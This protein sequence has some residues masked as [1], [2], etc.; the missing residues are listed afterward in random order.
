ML[1]CT[2]EPVKFAA[3]WTWKV[4]RLSKTNRINWMMNETIRNSLTNFVNQT[5]NRTCY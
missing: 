3:Y 2:T 1:L 4:P 5:A